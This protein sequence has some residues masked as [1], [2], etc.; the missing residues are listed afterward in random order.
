MGDPLSHQACT[1]CAPSRRAVKCV[2]CAKN[3]NKQNTR[4]PPD[5]I[6]AFFAIRFVF[7][8]SSR[9]NCPAC[10]VQPFR[11]SF[12]VALRTRTRSRPV[13][14]HTACRIEV[15]SII[16]IKMASDFNSRIAR[17][18]R[19]CRGQHVWESTGDN[20]HSRF[21]VVLRRRRG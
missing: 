6:A 16:F 4:S 1:R 12:T 3:N 11:G 21:R 14:N 13:A 9:F 2:W 17:Q 7:C 19:R 20:V 5:M 18:I 8:S 10:P 15:G